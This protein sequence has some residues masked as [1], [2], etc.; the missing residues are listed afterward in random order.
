MN[1]FLVYLGIGTLTSAML[2]GFSLNKSSVITDDNPV[3][4]IPENINAIFEK[5]C[6]GCHNSESRND[7]AKEKFMIDKLTKLKKSKLA[8]KLSE[9]GEVMEEGEMPPEKFAAKYPDKVPSAEDTKILIEWANKT[10][11]SL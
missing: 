6:F 3:I 4:E 5:S 1:K 11:D 8:A 10:A 9:I 2:F 7:K